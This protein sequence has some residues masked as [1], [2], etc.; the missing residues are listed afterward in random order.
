[1]SKLIGSN[2]A[3]NDQKSQSSK[4]LCCFHIWKIQ[5]ISCNGMF[6]LSQSLNYLTQQFLEVLIFLD[7]F[8]FFN[9]FEFLEYFLILEFLNFLELLKFLEFKEFRIFLFFYFL[10]FIHFFGICRNLKNF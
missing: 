8:E 10:E 1:M 4:C 7:F 2:L 3:T 6:Q 5:I 9:L